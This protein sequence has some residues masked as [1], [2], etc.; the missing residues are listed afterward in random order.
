MPGR[1]CESVA[2]GSRGVAAGR[3]KGDGRV[4]IAKNDGPA[5]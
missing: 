1:I 2:F 3:V 4:F 5:V